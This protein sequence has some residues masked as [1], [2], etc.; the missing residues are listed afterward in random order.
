MLALAAI[1]LVCGLCSSLSYLVF[2]LTGSR[3]DTVETNVVLG[4]IAGIGV[5]LGAAFLWQGIGTLMERGAVRAT[6][7]FPPLR[8]FILLFLVAIVIGLGALAFQTLV[9]SAVV[10]TVVAYAFPP[11]HFIAALVPPAAMV[12]YAAHRL[13]STSGVRA[14]LVSFGW[15]SLGATAL[16][17][18]AELV[19]AGVLLVGAAIAISR[20]SNSQALID[21]LRS[22]LDLTR[23]TKDVSSAAR[24]LNDPAV[25][26]GIL[27]YAAVLIPFVEE[28]LKTLVVAFVDPRKTQLGDAVL[29][30]MAAGAGFAVFENLFNTSA[31]LALW[32]MTA[33]LRIGATT[34]HVANGATMGRGWYAARVEGRWNRLLIGY[35][36]S[37]GLHAA[38]NA[39]ALLL[40]SSATYY[41]SNENASPG[42]TVPAAALSAALFL[43]IVVLAAIGL[44]WMAY[45]V[46]SA[47]RP[48]Q[49][50]SLERSE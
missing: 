13:G 15:G 4:A 6:R 10:S 37:V 28:A 47:Q 30:G 19:I 36:L 46:R 7:I 32:A 40:S 33:V 8:V 39:S 41:L 12:A 23:G 24:L 26:A 20:V 1:L 16:A 44:V 17:L 18:V 38:W 3:G 5:L 43:V 42:L 27:L 34:M 29:W 50:K 11:W 35:L 2:P 45:S 31:T 14:L 9:R 49:E 48:P 22:E 21:Q 25:L